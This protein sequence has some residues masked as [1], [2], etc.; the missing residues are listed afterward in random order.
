MEMTTKTELI[1]TALNEIEMCE[2]IIELAAAHLE[3]Y[4][5]AHCGEFNNKAVIATFRGVLVALRD[6]REAFDKAEAGLDS[7]DEMMGDYSLLEIRDLLFLNLLYTSEFL[8]TR[9]SRSGAIEIDAINTAC[10][11]AMNRRD[12][13]VKAIKALEHLEDARPQGPAMVSL[14]VI[15]LH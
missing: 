10:V 4:R 5:E 2:G 15:S 8:G 13:A 9:P 11:A 14:P 1:Q 7:L 3:V 6:L 12:A